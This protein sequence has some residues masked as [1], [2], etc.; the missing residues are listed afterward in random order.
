MALLRKKATHK[1]L[2]K[3]GIDDQNQVKAMKSVTIIISH[4]V[5]A[6]ANVLGDKQHKS[7]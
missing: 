6:H 4:V 2:E 3:A 1:E 7:H 5:G